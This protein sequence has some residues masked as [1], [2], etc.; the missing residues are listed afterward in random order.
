MT[1]VWASARF[2]PAFFFWWWKVRACCFGHL[3][4][5]QWT[6]RLV[7][8]V[9]WQQGQ[10]RKGRP[11]VHTRPHK[12]HM[13]NVCGNP[14]RAQHAQKAPTLKSSVRTRQ[15]RQS[16]RTGRATTRGLATIAS[17]V[18]ADSSQAT[19]AAAQAASASLPTSTSPP[20]PGSSPHQ[21][22][23]ARRLN[24]DAKTMKRCLDESTKMVVELG[25]FA[26]N[27]F[28]KK[29][30]CP[31]LAKMKQKAACTCLWAVRELGLRYTGPP[32]NGPGFY[33]D[34]QGNGA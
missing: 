18:P 4:S 29:I 17:H 15:P 9:P 33:Q 13:P 26:V 2:R 21:V 22:N 11:A 5:K 10:S 19:A 23:E 3:A 6:R 7:P 25:K 34:D 32:G 28:L 24:A 27:A 31:L 14:H 20:T 30:A 12:T 8:H 16:R 1:L